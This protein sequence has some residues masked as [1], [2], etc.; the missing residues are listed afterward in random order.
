MG[1]RKP[2]PQF[3]S[4]LGRGGPRSGS[5]RGYAMAE[6][7]K[8]P[9]PNPAT[10]AATTGHPLRMAS[11]GS[12]LKEAAG[13]F[14]PPSCPA[15]RRHPGLDPGIHDLPGARLDQRRGWPGQARR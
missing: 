13:H 6:R 15:L 1:I 5:V 9:H 7:Q 3:L 4:P 10:L 8:S 14:N 12:G 2:A 11:I